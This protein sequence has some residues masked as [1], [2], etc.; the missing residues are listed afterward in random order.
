MKNLFSKIKVTAIVAV[1]SL[2]SVNSFAQLSQA[3]N[4]DFDNG[5]TEVDLGLPSDKI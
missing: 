3:D 2:F 5:A 4:F 1:M